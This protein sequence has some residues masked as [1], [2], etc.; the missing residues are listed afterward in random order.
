M[1]LAAIA[2][3]FAYPLPITPEEEAIALLIITKAL[4]ELKFTISILNGFIDS[5]GCFADF[6]L[7]LIGNCLYIKI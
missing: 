1:N 6:L 7:F 3:A 4:N 5:A 2:P